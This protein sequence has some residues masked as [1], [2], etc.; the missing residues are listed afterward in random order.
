MENLFIGY[1]RCSTCKKA[2]KWLKD[3]N[4]EFKQREIV[5]D[6]PTKD[7]LNKWINISGKEIKSFFNTSG[8]VYK[9]LNLKDKLAK[10]SEDEEIEL[11]ASNGKLI[12]RPIF[13]NDNVV[14]LGFKEQEWKEKLIN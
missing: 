7:E 1:V 8:L 9:E 5:E 3:N 13:V 12:K 2:Q 14:L 11:L 10:M 6:V 4:I